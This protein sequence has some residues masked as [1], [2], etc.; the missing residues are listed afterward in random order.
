MTI[1]LVDSP[2]SI[3]GQVENTVRSEPTPKKVSLNLH[4]MGIQQYVSCSFGTRQAQR[5][6]K[7]SCNTTK[8]TWVNRASRRQKLRPVLLL[9]GAKLIGLKEWT[10]TR[11]PLMYL[12]VEFVGLAGDVNEYEL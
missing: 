6:L 11:R 12:G 3:A 1:W 5:S 7:L 2:P 9:N 8:R 10:R 4:E